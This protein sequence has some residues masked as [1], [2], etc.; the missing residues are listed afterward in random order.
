LRPLLQGTLFPNLQ[1]LGLRNSEYTDAIAIAIAQAPILD[2]L[3]ILDL[4]MG[5]LG[6]KG[7]AALLQSDKVPRLE[8]LDLHHHFLTDDMMHRLSQLGIALDLSEREELDERD[9]ELYRY[10]AVS[11]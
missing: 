11:E 5:T 8:K 10:V 4:S 6:D 3:R 7:G 2:R 1:Y 9:G